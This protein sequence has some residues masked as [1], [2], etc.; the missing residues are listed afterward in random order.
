MDKIILAYYISTKNINTQEG[1]EKL[2]TDLK[3][4]VNDDNVIQLIIPTQDEKN[5][6]ECVYPKFVVSDN[7]IEKFEDVMSRFET[8]LN[9]KFDEE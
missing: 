6:V 4:T 8:I 5:R 1:F 7:N 3:N 2:S 9:K